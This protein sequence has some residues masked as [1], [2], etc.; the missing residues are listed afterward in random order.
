MQETWVRHLDW[1][2]TLEKGVVTHSSVLSWRIPWAE[3]PWGRQESDTSEWLALS[4]SFSY[5]VKI[6]LQKPK[7]KNQLLA[8]KYEKS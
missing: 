7:K 3:G 6:A 5:N 2:N 1:D 8:Q 4:L